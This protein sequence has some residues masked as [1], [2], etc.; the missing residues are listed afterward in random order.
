MI[1]LDSSVLVKRYVSEPDSDRAEAML[2]DDPD[3][4]TAQHAFVEVAIALARRVPSETLG[5]AMEALERD[6]ARTAVVAVDDT[7]CRR[8]ARIGAEAGSRSLDALHL[9]AAER[10]GVRAIP[11]LTF[12]LRLAHAARILGFEVRGS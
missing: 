2:L 12:D 6:W 3:W 10:V 11:I 1:Y 8:A 9:A 7:L 4:V 5:R